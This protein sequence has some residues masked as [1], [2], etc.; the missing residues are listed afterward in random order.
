M[1]ELASDAY[2]LAP[3]MP[4]YGDADKPFDFDYSTDGYARHIGGIVKEL[5]I[6]R[7]HLVLHDLGGPWGLA[8]AAAN[9]D[10]LA[11]LTLIGIGALPGYRWHW[12][13]QLYRRRIL[14]ELVLATSTAATFRWAG[15]QGSR[16]GLPREFVERSA[17]SYRDRSTRRA[18]LAYY[19][20]T[21]DLGAVTVAS[22]DALREANPRTLVVWGR[23][24]PYLPVK[25][26]AIQRDFFE[27]SEIHV[28]DGSGHWPHLDDPAAVAGLL[29]RFLSRQQPSI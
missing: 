1:K 28:L 17:R 16:N 8:W 9:P 20:A 2:C 15:S 14:G 22:A 21:P 11:S 5:G 19:R 13:G 4:G 10:A 27:R 7:A 18:V 6:R 26:A 12:F 25:Y 3:D 29:Q 23:G 24:D